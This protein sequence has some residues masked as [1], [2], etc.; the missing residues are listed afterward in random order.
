MIRVFSQDC[1]PKNA[2][3][4]QQ[5]SG[6]TLRWPTWLSSWCSGPVWSNFECRWPLWLACDQ[7]NVAKMMVVT[8]VITLHCTRLY[9]TSTSFFSILASKKQ[10]ATLWEL[11]VSKKPGLSLNSDKE[12]NSDNNLSKSGSGYMTSQVSGWEPNLGQH[13]DWN[14]TIQLSYAQTPD[15]QK[16]L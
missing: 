12:V 11:K 10:A 4:F 14:L 3:V 13:L 8:L 9:L 16:K 15:S 6:Y 7:Q 2:P 1:L 5:C